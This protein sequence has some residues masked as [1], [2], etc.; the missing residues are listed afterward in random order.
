MVTRRELLIGGAT[1]IAAVSL[2]RLTRA[3][4]AV[5]TP[6]PLPASP[7]APSVVDAI[8]GEC[9]AI[10]AVRDSIRALVADAAAGHRPRLVLIIGQTGVGKDQIVRVL[11]EASQSRGAYV[12]VIPARIGEG[13]TAR[14]LFGSAS[15]RSAWE[16]ARGG[17]VAIDMLDFVETRLWPRLVRTLENG[18]C[19]RSGT[20]ITEP[21]D[22]W[23]IGMTHHGLD[24]W[25]GEQTMRELLASLDPVVLDVPPLRER[26][27][28]IH[29]LADHFLARHSR[30]L[31]RP[32]RTLTPNARRMLASYR[33]PGNVR[34]LENVM[35]IQMF[36]AASVQIDHGDLAEM[37]G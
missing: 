35:E 5:A 23:T 33:W 8:V 13:R 19:R 18:R 6:S 3:D 14:V 37:I 34:E 17:T 36:R 30:E 11:H 22:A 16:C 2:T 28:D 32:I 21:I 29:L 27:D 25:I 1:A 24:A 10:R 12:P 4:A 31:N 9:P 7:P 26:G 15:R 20:Q